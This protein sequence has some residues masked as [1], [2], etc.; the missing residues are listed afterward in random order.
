M[1]SENW[2][3][4][5]AWGDFLCSGDGREMRVRMILHPAPIFIGLRSGRKH[6][7]KH[8]KAEFRTC[9]MAVSH[10]HHICVRGGPGMSNEI[11]RHGEGHGDLQCRD[12]CDGCVL[13]VLSAD[14]GPGSQN[15]RRD[16]RNR[17][18]AYQFP[19]SFQGRLRS[20]RESNQSRLRKKGNR[21]FLGV[22]KAMARTHLHNKGDVCTLL[23]CLPTTHQSMGGP[24]NTS[25][26]TSVIHHQPL[27]VG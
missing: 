18:T 6:G 3:Y 19:C 12:S 10:L 16:H 26:L 24:L 20:Y 9:A 13:Y 27:Q 23:R 11:E 21:A 4:R 14:L 7:L 15:E 22:W 8:I 25:R 2:C 17:G 5:R 1:H